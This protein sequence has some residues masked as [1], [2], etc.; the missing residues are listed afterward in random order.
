MNRVVKLAL[1]I[2]SDW[3]YHKPQLFVIAELDPPSSGNTCRHPD[4]AGNWPIGIITIRTKVTRTKVIQRT[5]DAWVGFINCPSQVGRQSRVSVDVNVQSQLTNQTYLH[6][7]ISHAP[8]Y[9]Y[10]QTQF[11]HHQF[12]ACEM[13][14]SPEMDEIASTWTT[15]LTW[16]VPYYL[17]TCFIYFMIIYM[18]YICIYIYML[19][20]YI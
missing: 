10:E 6:A 7:S 12:L 13:P 4:R 18:I 11:V 8:T 20:R 1:E 16:T 3:S 15:N 19:L 2:C 5:Y 14:V 9:R 17:R